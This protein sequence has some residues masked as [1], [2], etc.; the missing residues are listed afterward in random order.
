MTVPTEANTFANR[1]TDAPKYQKICPL[2]G[3]F[4]L[5]S[6]R[7]SVRHI[8]DCGLLATTSIDFTYLSKCIVCAVAAKR[9]CAPGIGATRCARVLIVARCSIHFSPKMPELKDVRWASG[10]A[11]SGSRLTLYEQQCRR[12]T[13]RADDLRESCFSGTVKSSRISFRPRRVSKQPMQSIPS[14]SGTACRHT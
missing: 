1:L 13:S 9:R 2:S 11:A 12:S 5:K 3:D 8:A 4:P 14:P 10:I 7:P 6:I